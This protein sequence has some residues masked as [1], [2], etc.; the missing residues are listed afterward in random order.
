MSS[1]NPPT[2]RLK[3]Y[4]EL[5]QNDNVYNG[6]AI[7]QH[8]VLGGVGVREVEGLLCALWN[9]LQRIPNPVTLIG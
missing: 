1:G 5:N 9:R 2:D 6:H 3:K 4:A 8:L 7:D